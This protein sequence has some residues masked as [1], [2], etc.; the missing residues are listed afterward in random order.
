MGSTPAIP[1]KSI[2]TALQGHVI[3]FRVDRL[4]KTRVSS[5]Q[6]DLMPDRLLGSASDLIGI[7]LIPICTVGVCMGAAR[8][9]R[10]FY[11]DVSATF[12][13][14]IYIYQATMKGFARA[15]THVVLFVDNQWYGSSQGIMNG[16]DTFAHR[17][18]F[19]FLFHELVFY[20]GYT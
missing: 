20:R 5:L 12:F 8:L 13:Q 6:G 15:E 17:N 16:S 19:P 10:Y 14:L 9:H 18:G 4:T 1:Y 11:Q 7:E 2:F 3:Q